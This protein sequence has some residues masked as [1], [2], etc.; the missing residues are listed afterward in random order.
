MK[1]TEIYFFI[2]EQSKNQIIKRPDMKFMGAY[3]VFHTSK[4][5][6]VLR[7]HIMIRS[8]KWVKDLCMMVL[9]FSNNSIALLSS[10]T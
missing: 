4:H 8:A 2:D 9:H 5:Q 6:N 3:S 7:D 1:N 10:H